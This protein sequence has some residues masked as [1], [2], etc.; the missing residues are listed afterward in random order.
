[1][2]EDAQEY[3]ESIYPIVKEYAPQVTEIFQNK[4]YNKLSHDN[5]ETSKFNKATMYII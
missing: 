3:I 1:M 4:W 2:I 5:L